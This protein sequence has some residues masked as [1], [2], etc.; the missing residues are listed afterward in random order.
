[1]KLQALSK[2]SG[3]VLIFLFFCGFDIR[4]RVL[5]DSPTPDDIVVVNLAVGRMT[6]LSFS[7][8][9][10]VVTLGDE[11]LFKVERTQKDVYIKPLLAQ[12]ETNLFCWTDKKRYNFHLVIG[13]VEKV[14]YVLN[15]DSIIE[16]QNKG[17]KLSLQEM[18]YYCRVYDQLSKMG[19]LDER[20][21]ERITVNKL[22]RNEAWGM[23]LVVKD[24]F[25]HQK[26]HWLAVSAVI[27]NTG[28]NIKILK[29][30]LSR[31]YVN[32]RAILPSYV[33]FD[34]TE[35]S[36][37]SSTAVYFVLEGTNISKENE[38]IPSIGI[39]NEEVIFEK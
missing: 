34:L 1:M 31:L 36:Q 23:G 32:G 39:E 21:L 27:S 26:P 2:I 25:F 8:E 5:Y 30:N 22:Y 6:V 37:G 20:T 17:K 15:V 9:V 24:I 4:N 14:N 11:E 38:F 35:L 19:V 7:D 10:I 28:Q 3:L 12:G 16:Q 13:P 29:E 33:V 18:L